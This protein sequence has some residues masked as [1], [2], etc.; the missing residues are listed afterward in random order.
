[1][2]SRRQWDRTG[3]FP[4]GNVLSVCTDRE[5]DSLGGALIPPSRLGRAALRQPQKIETEASLDG[6][7]GLAGAHRSHHDPFVMWKS[8]ILSVGLATGRGEGRTPTPC[9]DEPT[10]EVPNP[11]VL[12]KRTWVSDVAV[13][14]AFKAT[15]AMITV[16][17]CV[18]GQESLPTI[19]PGTA[20]EVQL[21]AR[22]GEGVQ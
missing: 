19:E 17:L 2:C 8:A 11:T 13:R 12:P 21:V 16:P 5:R 9:P 3:G 15:S 20:V 6:G 1:M 22:V 18:V 4:S 10:K 14:F 7:E